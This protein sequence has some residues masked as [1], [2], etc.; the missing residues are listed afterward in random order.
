[1]LRYYRFE[2]VVPIEHDNYS[3]MDDIIQTIEH[4]CRYYLPENVSATM[5]DDSTGYSRRL[6]RAIHDQSFETFASIVKEFNR[7]LRVAL[8]DGTVASR[9]KES[10]VLDL[11]L[12]DRITS[13]IY[14]R[15]VSP[16]VESLKKYENGT[17]N[18]YGEVLTSFASNI[19]AETHLQ[20]DGVFV[21][22]GSGVGN[23]VL[24]A[25]LEIGCESWG[26]EQMHNPA[27]LAAEK[28]TQ[29]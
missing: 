15:T 17:S 14:S 24:Q 13:Q 21:D 25:A 19:F 7:A 20:S 16:K 1:M 9:L 3:P 18:V 12:I 2:L 4:I 10:P 26:I 5:L 8:D 11:P 29:F 28:P 22:M 6:K 27:S 23:V